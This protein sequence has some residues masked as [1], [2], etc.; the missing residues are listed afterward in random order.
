MLST[1]GEEY[2]CRRFPIRTRRNV[3]PD[4]VSVS[5]EEEKSRPVELCDEAKNDP[6]SLQAMEDEIVSFKR[7]NCYK[8]VSSDMFCACANIT[9]T[10]WIISKR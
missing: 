2:A 7:F 3:Y 8:E 10:R 5:S 1:A 4:S 6:S 9:S